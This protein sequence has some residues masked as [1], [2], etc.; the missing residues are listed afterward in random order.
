MGFGLLRAQPGVADD[1]GV[2]REHGSCHGVAAGLRGVDVPSKSAN[3]G[4]TV[5]CAKLSGENSAATLAA[6]LCFLL[7]VAGQDSRIPNSCG[8]HD[9]NRMVGSAS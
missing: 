6:G 9:R 5:L 1:I 2:S 3:A 8:D 4:R 7:A